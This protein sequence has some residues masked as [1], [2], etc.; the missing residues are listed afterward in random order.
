LSLTHIDLFSGIGG[1]ALACQWNGI[2]TEVF[3][4]KDKYCQRVLREHWPAVPIISDIAEFD[5][6]AYSGSFILSSGDPCPIRSK[7]KSIWKTK[8]PDLSGYALKVVAGSQPE[9]VLR[10]NVPAPDDV[11]FTA[12]LEAIGYR[13]VIVAT[14]ASKVTA[15]NRERDFIVANRDPG[16]IYDFVHSLPVAENA[17][18]YA[19][20]KCEKTDAYPVL[21]THA[22]RWDARD[23][24]IWDGCGIKVANSQERLAFAGFPCDWLDGLSKTTV[25]RMT[26]NAIVPQVAATIIKY[27]KEV[28][29]CTE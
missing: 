11:H 21:T 20:T 19:E 13:C 9:W 8:Q 6:S 5:G 17:Q 25:A 28:D 3:C 15:Q 14:N 24:Y 1:F 27:I 16:K 26:G 7:A 29:P 4:E 12:A 2:Q 23:G 10:E 18:R 22:C